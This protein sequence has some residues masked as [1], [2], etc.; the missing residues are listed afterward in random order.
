MNKSKYVA[1][2]IAGV[3]LISGGAYGLTDH[4]TDKPKKET[5]SSKVLKSS[6]KETQKASN[7]SKPKFEYNVENFTCKLE[8]GIWSNKIIPTE[9][10]NIDYHIN[11]VELIN[12]NDPMLQIKYSVENKTDDDFTY[13][14][15]DI[16]NLITAEDKNN[17]LSVVNSDSEKLLTSNEK[18]ELTTQYELSSNKE[19]AKEITLILMK[20]D[21]A[22]AKKVYQFDDNKIN[23]VYD[24]QNKVESSQNNE[25]KQD[26]VQQNQ[27]Q[28]NEQ[29]QNNNQRQNVANNNQNN[30][31]NQNN[32]NNQ[33][34]QAVNQTPTNGKILG[35]PK[36]GI[37][38]TPDSIHYAKIADNADR[39]EFNSVEEALAAGYRMSKN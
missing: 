39:V 10:G 14:Q 12:D 27:Q 19:D 20:G 9:K 2:L 17:K 28:N 37:A 5:S 21:K 33:N 29:N 38:F 11:S 3:L 13:N 8:E 26:V 30:E 7:S 22:V 35:N 32:Q 34:N 36:S 4:K 24:E 6:K 15:I 23:D 25:Q 18:V 1:G 16:D 31:Q